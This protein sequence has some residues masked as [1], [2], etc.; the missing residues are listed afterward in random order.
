MP[1]QT[2]LLLPCVLAFALLQEAHSAYA[3]A[4]NPLLQ[5]RPF[6]PGPSR[7]L[8]DYRFLKHP[9]RRTDPLDGLRYHELAE[10]SW[11]QLGGEA[12]YASFSIDHPDFELTPARS[13]DYLQ[14][15]AQLHGSLH[16][17]DNAVRAF[18]QVQNVRSWNQKTMTRRDETGTDVA[19]AFIDTNVHFGSVKAAAR[20]GRQELNYGTGALVNIGEPRNIRL[21]F[22]GARVMLGS[23]TANVELFAVRPV[24]AAANNFDDKTDKNVKFYGIYANIPV[25][26][27]LGVDLYAFGHKRK[28]RAFQGFT[29]AEDRE[30]LGTRL[31]GRARQ[32]DWNWDMM[33]QRGEHAQRD[34][35]AWAVTGDAGYTLPSAAKIR[36]GLLFD[37]ASGGQPTSATV[38]RTFDPLYPRNG[39]YGE[40]AVNTL[41]NMTMFGLS[42]AFSPTPTTRISSSVMK[43][44]RTSTDDY[45]YL[46]NLRPLAATLRNAD[47]DIGTNY[48]MSLVWQPVRNLSAEVGL[49]NYKAGSTVLKAGGS[50]VRAAVVRAGVRF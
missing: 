29:G 24:V 37:R 42:L 32:L 28:A 10:S 23:S 6:S 50:D 15:R 41:A 44:A 27:A 20:I 39:M 13:D 45:V 33:V 2:P 12:R 48:Q 5:A 9:S 46:P 14:Q 34:I 36:V 17:M 47:D 7:W 1:E 30:T 43:F 35:R 40:A 38:T 11:L 3:Q 21:A 26:A 19:Q 49:M 31:F 22:Q 18:L 4:V 25:M 16:L 8:E